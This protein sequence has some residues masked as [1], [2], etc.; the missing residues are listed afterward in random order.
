M[1]LG[2]NE[3][4]HSGRGDRASPLIALLYVGVITKPTSAGCV[5]ENNLFVLSYIDLFF[6]LCTDLIIDTNISI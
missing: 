5:L 6:R 1:C 3:A 4:A 2:T